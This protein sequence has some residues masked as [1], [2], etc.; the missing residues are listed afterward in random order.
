MT[1]LVERTRRMLD[2][3]SAPPWEVAPGR[4]V[5]VVGRLGPVALTCGDGTEPQP[6]W[7]RDATLIAGAPSLLAELADEVERLRSENDQLRRTK[8]DQVGDALGRYARAALGDNP[9]DV[10]ETSRVLN[11]AIEQ[12][13][14]SPSEPHPPASASES[15]AAKPRKP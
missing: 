11:E 12:L 4:N 2:G 6:R 10:A 5:R 8:L 15:S 3:I 9:A 7:Q 13:R 1:D 14:A